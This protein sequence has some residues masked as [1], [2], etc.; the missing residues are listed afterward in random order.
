MVGQSVGQQCVCFVPRQALTQGDLQEAFQQTASLSQRGL[1]V[2]KP[3]SP[4]STDLGN[5][6]SQPLQRT[7]VLHLQMALWRREVGLA[8]WNAWVERKK[9]CHLTQY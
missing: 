3:A 1:G 7:C 9:I 4:L 8:S 5:L 2:L 6:A